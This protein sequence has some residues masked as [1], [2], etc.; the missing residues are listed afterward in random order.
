MKKFKGYFFV[1]LLGFLAGGCAEVSQN[2]GQNIAMISE[3]PK[4][5]CTSLGELS[6][7]VGSG[8]YQL[9]E[10]K[11]RAAQKGANT[12]LVKSQKLHFRKQISSME[13]TTIIEAYRCP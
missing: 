1:P 12:I 5:N 6:S 13:T 9:K 10:L 8:P 3:A 11:N 4:N 2:L 7:S